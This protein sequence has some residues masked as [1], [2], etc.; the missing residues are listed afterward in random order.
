MYETEIKQIF[1]V[2]EEFDIQLPNKLLDERVLIGRLES[3]LEELDDNASEQ[4]YDRGLDDAR[5][6]EDCCYY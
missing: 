4:G 6:Y 1:R 5:C 3:I 2:L